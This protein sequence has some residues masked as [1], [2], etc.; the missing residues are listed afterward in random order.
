MKLSFK[1]LVGPVPISRRTESEVTEAGVSI[2]K[3]DRSKLSTF[4]KLKLSKS[5]REGGGG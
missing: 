1:N 2:K 3:N 4:D 5:A